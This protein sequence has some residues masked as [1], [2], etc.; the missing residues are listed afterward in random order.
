MRWLECI[1]SVQQGIQL[2]RCQWKVWSHSFTQKWA[3]LWLLHVSFQGENG[4]F[5]QVSPQVSSLNFT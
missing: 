2:G 3:G 5:W 1:A 4:V